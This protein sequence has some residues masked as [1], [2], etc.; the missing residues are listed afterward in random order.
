MEHSALKIP[1]GFILKTIVLNAVGVCLLLT[2]ALAQAPEEIKVKDY[3][4]KSIYKIP[5]SKIVKAKYPA[6]DIHS[7]PYATTSQEMT[8]WVRN[9]DEA[10]IQ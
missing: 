5:V 2:E 7:H 1:R 4:P 3:R 9:M 10:G 6:I 8:E